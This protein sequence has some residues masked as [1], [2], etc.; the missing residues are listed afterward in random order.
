MSRYWDID[1]GNPGA[2]H[3]EGTTAKEAVIKSREKIAG[4]LNAHP[5]ELIFNSGGTESNNLA[6]FGVLTRLNDKGIA[7]SEM[8]LIT[9]V[10]EHSSVLQCFKYF[11]NKGAQ[12]NYINIGKDG[13]ID[14][15][16]FKELLNPKTVFV[17]IMSVNNEIGTIQPIA[18]VAKII[19]SFQ[20]RNNQLGS[21]PI[22]HSDAA[23]ALLFLPINTQKLGADMMSFD[24]QKIYGPK[25]IGVLYVKKGIEINPLIIGGGQ[26][27]SLRPGTENVPL[28]V[29]FAKAL[30]MAEKEKEKESQRLIRLRNY[31]INQVLG[32]ISG[33]KLNGDSD[34]RLCNNVNIF[35]PHQNN[36]FMVIQL[37][38]KKIAC[39]TKSACLTEKNSSY[40]V[41]S[42]GNGENRGKNSIRFTMGKSTTKKDID[43][44]IKCLVKICSNNN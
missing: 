37:D 7:Y 23:Q 25:G 11:E 40:V 35:F 13:I 34:K 8:S 14:L 6:I 44:L 21:L 41:N 42:L 18:E 5:N 32:K 3:K 17:S 33:T 10:F 36:E 29:G 20:K 28:I 31:F 27:K 39:S 38:K 26:E 22:L 2:I 1:F 30:E 24:A 4:F 15:K 12:V 19:H 9:T 43:Y 16:H